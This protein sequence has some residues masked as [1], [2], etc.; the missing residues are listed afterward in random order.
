[1]ADETERSRFALAI[2]SGE[3]TEYPEKA[4]AELKVM[5]EIMK[6]SN[7]SNFSAE[8]HPL[9][10]AFQSIWLRIAKVS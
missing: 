3:L 6:S 1:M 7:P 8:E 5:A 4:K 9:R 10:Y 2:D